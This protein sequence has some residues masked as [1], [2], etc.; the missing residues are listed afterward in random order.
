MTSV[1][2]VMQP[3][4]AECRPASALAGTAIKVALLDD[5]E[6]NNILMAEALRDLPGIEIVA[7]T[8]PAEALAFVRSHAAEIGLAF[9]DFD[10]PGTNGI[11]F[12]RQSRDVPGF[13]HVP[14]VMVTSVD[15]RSVRREAL[16]AGATDFLRKPF[17]ALEVRAR[18]GNLL[19]LNAALREQADRAAWLAREVAAAVAVIESR[20]REI[21]VRLARAAEHRDT[22]TGD[23][24]S[25]VAAFA[26]GIAAELGCPSEWCNRLALA[27]TMH[28]IGKIAVPDAILLKPG[29]LTSEERAVITRHAE[30]GHRILEGS[31]SDVIQLAAE[32]ALTHHERWDGDGY[33]RGLRGDA[34][35]LSGRIV[36]VADVFD[37]LCSPRPYKRAWSDAE[38]KTYLTE[39]AGTQFDPD[40]VDAF[41]RADQIGAL[42]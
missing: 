10:M 29:L 2:H 30:D 6:L 36:A 16:E 24:I 27:A 22:D 13:A 25:R 15:Q 11:G 41:M 5:D 3:P 18:A 33:P 39:N 1:G 28:D 42:A 32:V 38:A 7:F 23:H 21:V 26:R 31:S 34:I 35:P 37:A 9:T 4:V 8:E 20:E 14:I 19:A 40:C 12:V 17:D